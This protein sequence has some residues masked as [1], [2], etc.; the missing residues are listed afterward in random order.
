MPPA[1]RSDGD[2][3][4]RRYYDSLDELERKERRWGELEALLYQGIGRLALTAYGRSGALDRRL[5][6]LRQALRARR[7]PERVAALIDL[8]AEAA[9]ALA[10]EDGASPDARLFALRLLDRLEPPAA[11][12]R[13]V[14]RLKKRLAATGGD[15]AA[16]A[17][18][19]AELVTE[20]ARAREPDADRRE[21]GGGVLRRLFAR[22][23]EAGARRAEA[24]QPASVEACELL[25][26]LLAAIELPEPEAGEQRALRARA[27]AD[28]DPLELGEA[29]AGLV[30]RACAR[31]A[32]RDQGGGEAGGEAARRTLE[33]ALREVLLGLL[34]QVELPAEAQERLAALRERVAGGIDA[35]GLAG[36]LAS[37]AGLIGELRAEM[38]RE[39]L[40]M[41]AFL[42]G[43]SERLGHI[44]GAL[45][46]SLAEQAASLDG[47]RDL[48]RSVAG[49]IDGM[50]GEVAAAADLEDLRRAVERRLLAIA[51]HVEHHLGEE[52]ERFERAN[53]RIERL[54]A[55]LH[56]TREET[57]RLRARIEE[58]QERA[59]HDGLTGVANR[60]AFDERLAA[61]H[62]RVARYG[63]TFTVLFW[64]LDHFKAINDT[65]GHEAG[66]RVLCTVA[67]LLERELR[68]SDL[69]ARYGG[70]EFVILMPET[71]LEGALQVAEK[72]RA[73]VA[74]ANFHYR[75]Q[76]VPVTASCGA[77]ELRRGESV[78]ELLRRADAA[79]YAAKQAGRNRCQAAA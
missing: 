76:P 8:V 22:E 55:D 71:D 56:E 38:R 75:D 15:L 78:A 17:E 11:L 4:K 49:Q 48:E 28:E 62:A 5:D 74:G 9:E 65:W 7:D 10:G 47:S 31:L 29:L 60:A 19:L 42:A 3:W 23:D 52:N 27:A 1:G 25:G 34:E 51:E 63:G 13:K 20:M 53:R 57:E 46:A 69:L 33:P 66:D 59:S 39:R 2:R 21:P 26:R 43:L 77:A 54:E 6:R 50:R 70:E 36:V 72:L 30:N 44:D 58:E 18:A 64:D 16:E 41:E 32:E 35:E 73:A 37:L 24:P 12:E 45:A 40:D 14:L 79:L 61:E 67:R 68:A